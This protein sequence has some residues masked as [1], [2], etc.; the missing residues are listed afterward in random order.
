MMMKW[1]QL[2]IS[3]SLSRN[4]CITSPVKMVKGRSKPRKSP[5]RGFKW[6]V[7]DG[8]CSVSFLPIEW[9]SS[10]RVIMIVSDLYRREEIWSKVSGNF[11]RVKVSS[12]TK[13]A[14]RPFEASIF[15][16]RRDKKENNDRVMVIEA[17]GENYQLPFHRRLLLFMDP[18]FPCVMLVV[19][20]EKEE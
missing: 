13:V 15:N 5:N 17:K 20:L 12:C 2:A 16:K 10:L 14:M 9:W 7:K 18:L 4:H 3:K 8:F 1:M 11:K 19:L 6:E